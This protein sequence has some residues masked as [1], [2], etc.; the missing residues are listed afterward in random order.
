MTVPLPT[1]R[2]TSALAR[3]IARSLRGRDLLLLSGEL[4]SGKTTLV[5]YLARA[6]GIPPGW[7]S[8]PSFTLIQRYPAG[9]AGVG[10]THVDLYRLGRQPEAE[11][12]GLEEI[13]AG[14]DLVV[15][16]WPELGGALWA[17]SGRPVWRVDLRDGPRG[18]EADVLEPEAVRRKQ[19]AGSREGKP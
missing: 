18:R 13:L 1:L 17:E 8:S 19:E 12:L 4:G 9:K 14:D 10:V 7:V 3:R 11:G 5:R 15:V 2:A 16:E 6:L